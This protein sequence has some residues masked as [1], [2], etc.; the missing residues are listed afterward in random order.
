MIYLIDSNWKLKSLTLPFGWE[1]V[2]GN[3]L[4]FIIRGVSY[5]KQDATYESAS[6]NIAIL[7]AGNLQ[8]GQ[9]IFDDLVFVPQH[10]VDISQL[11]C[12]GDLVVAMSSGSASVVGKVSSVEKDYNTVS[13][14][15][16]CALIRPIEASISRWIS[17]YFQTKHYRNYIS[18]V[19]AGVNINNLRPSHLLE[20][21]IPL[22]PLNEQRRIVTK[23]EV[24][25]AR[26]QRVKDALED[27]PQLLDQ[28]RQSVLAAAFRGDLTADWREQNPDVEPAIYLIKK[29]LDAHNIAGGHK[30]G[31]AAPPTDGVHNLTSDLFPNTWHMAELRDIC[32]PSR[33]ITYG[34]L[35]PGPEMQEGVPYIRV[36]DFPK[37]KLNLA[38]IRKTSHQID[39]QYTRSKLKTGDILLSIRGTV[40]RLCKIPNSLNEANITQDSARLS[41]QSIINTDYVLWILRSKPTQQRMQ[42]A[43]KGVAVRGI[44]IG[45]VRAL[46]IPIPPYSEQCEIVK[47]IKELFK[48]AKQIEQ[49]YQETKYNLDQLDQSIL[50]KAFRGELVLQDPNDEPASVLLERIRTESAK[51]ETKT[52][53]KSKAKT[54][55]RSTKKVQVQ[56]EESV[57]LEL[58]LE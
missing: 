36:A 40:G 5:K 46:Q 17:H 4:F 2:Q 51:L 32:E 10:L 47:R 50:A 55:S 7:R 1:L 58:G 9:I 33:P 21:Q 15:A 19:A 12:A 31:N 25:K 6:S 43:I 13:F 45:D 11:L 18:S 44:N 26:S 48:L 22:P 23:I 35:K 56:A 42:K 41:I 8:N 38:G 3:K 27:I 30:R 14:G 52:A 37:D 54:S 28:F 57:Q 34:I 24:L 16:F 49:K 39:A 53:K 29:A 20:M